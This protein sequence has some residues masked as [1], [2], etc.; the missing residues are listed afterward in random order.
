MKMTRNVGCLLGVG[1]VLL[2]LVFLGCGS[3]NGMV[4]QRNAVD[5]S[6]AQVQNQYQRRADLID[7]LVNTVKAQVKAENQTLTQVIAAR[8]QARGSFNNAA[9]V[10]GDSLTQERID[11]FQRSYDDYQRQTQLF[12]NVVSEQYPDLKSAGA[13]TEL[14]TEMSGTE[15]RVA[16]ARM[17]FNNAATAYNNRV[18]SFPNNIFAGMFG[19]S[20]RGLFQA[21]A[22]AE[23]APKVSDDF[24][25]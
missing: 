23:V 9:R 10:S 3:Y 21:Q 5:N 2:I 13:F 14:R 24:M 6:W 15:N 20:K 8:N 11:Q 18:Q 19:F 25:K 1:I 22:G 7:N 17:D 12:I 4:K 16:T